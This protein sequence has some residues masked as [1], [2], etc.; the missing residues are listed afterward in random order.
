MLA[1]GRD[2]E[3]LA[4]ALDAAV[5]GL[6]AAAQLPNGAG[7][8]GAGARAERGGLADGDRCRLE[9][10]PPPAARLRAAG[11]EEV[12]VRASEILG[13][14]S[15]SR[16]AG[17][18]VERVRITSADA[19][20]PRLRVSTDAGTDVAIQLERGSYLRDGAVLHDDGER[21]IVVERA[22]ENAMLVRLDPALERGEAIRLAL[23]LGHAFG[24][25]HLPVE[26]DDGEIRVP[27]TTSEE[28]LLGT[29][30]ALGLSG[31]QVTFAPTKLGRA[32]PLGAR[33]H[34]H[35]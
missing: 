23:R 24:N 15:A 5:S 17:R 35:D 19:E 2:A 7:A 27:V 11:G 1:P 22:L 6:G 31:A 32:Q 9:R 20:K 12:T 29:V 33:G 14:E 8:L 18:R 26:I 25:Q 3:A 4:A 16:F 21:I 13:D 30:T 28:I 34:H 10:R